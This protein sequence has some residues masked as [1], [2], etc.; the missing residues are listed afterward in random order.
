MNPGIGGARA[1]V[2]LVGNPNVGKSTVFGCLTGSYAEVSNFPG[3]TVEVFEGRMGDVAILDTP[4]VYGL[5]GFNDEEKVTRS[6]MRRAD[7]VV[8]VVDSVNLGRDLFL[9]LQLLVL[10]TRPVVFANLADELE[11]RHL[12]LDAGTLSSL[13]GL[14]VVT[15][16]AAT[17]RG[18]AEL[19]SLIVSE[20]ETGSRAARGSAP[21]RAVRVGAGANWSETD[22]RRFRSEADAIA[23]KSLTGSSRTARLGALFGRLTVHPLAGPAILAAVLWGIYYF[24]GYLV[25]QRTVDFTEKTL[26]Q[27]LALPLLNDA[28]LPLVG[29]DGP[30]FHLLLGRYGLAS[31]ALV[32]LFGLLL[33]LVASF[34]LVTGWLEDSGYLPRIAVLADRML[35]ALGLNGRAVIPLILGLGCVTMATMT[36]RILGTRRERFIASFLLALTVPCSAQLGVM[37]AMLGPLGP[38]YVLAWAAGVLAVF[39]AAGRALDQVLPGQSSPLLTDLPPLRLPRPQNVLAKT[40]RRTRWFLREAGPLLATASAAVA[41]SDYLGWLSAVEALL[42]PV[43]ET[44][45]RLPSEAAS[46]FLVGLL[47]RDF[48]AAGL[49]RIDLDPGQK[50]AAV[51]TMTLFVPCLASSLTIVKE[52]GRLEGIFLWSAALAAALILGGLAARLVPWF[53]L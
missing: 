47:R 31:M 28:L 36:T 39:L 9:T 44:W 12:R 42:R 40:Y 3:T 10:G 45:L 30:V 6:A 11:T 16:A 15:G 29:G 48:G 33:P 50:L 46:A 35:S 38:K 21:P 27:G 49:Y 5:S 18:L 41:L 23:A 37:A 52:R 20:L 7:L 25:A 43:F 51:F 8:N 34:S 14:P 53:G 1:T 26:M 24:L 2:L 22:F 17:G 13:L 32:Y 4:G 19:R